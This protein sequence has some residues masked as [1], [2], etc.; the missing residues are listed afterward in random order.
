[1]ALVSPCL[2]VSLLNHIG[3]TDFY[4]WPWKSPQ[5]SLNRE[6]RVE[7][8]R[9][10]HGRQYLSLGRPFNGPPPSLR[11]E[12]PLAGRI[13]LALLLFCLPAFSL[14]SHNQFLSSAAFRTS[15][16]LYIRFQK[17][18][19]SSTRS[20]RSTPAARPPRKCG[21]SGRPSTWA[22]PSSCHVAPRGATNPFRKTRA[23][24]WFSCTT[25]IC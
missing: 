25:R 12:L 11:E 4:H 14:S 13:E 10:G 16:R 8:E 5:N 23:G 9:S 1:M 7:S 18:G 20:A 15:H 6:R 19:L 3:V 17:A 21:R 22:S 24:C 2:W